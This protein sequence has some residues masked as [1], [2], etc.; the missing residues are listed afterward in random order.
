MTPK[1]ENVLNITSYL[2]KQTN[3]QTNKQKNR[4]ISRESVFRVLMSSLH[5][6]IMNTM[7]SV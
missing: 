3:K 7:H 5:H 2:K 1:D 4:K 6:S